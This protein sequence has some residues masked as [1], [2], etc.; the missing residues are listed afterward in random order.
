MQL[1]TSA[2][3]ALSSH[4]HLVWGSGILAF[5]W[6]ASRFVG[7]LENRVLNTETTVVKMATNDLPHIHGELQEVNTNLRVQTAVLEGLRDVMVTRL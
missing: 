6:K 5:L 7:K 3:N 1:A 4:F 2:F